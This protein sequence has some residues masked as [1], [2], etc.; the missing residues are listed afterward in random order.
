MPLLHRIKKQLRACENCIKDVIYDRRHDRKAQR[1]GFLFRCLALPF[2]TIVR[3][4]EQAYDKRWLRSQHLGC[5]VIVVGNLTVGGTGKTPIVEKLTR[6]LQARG[7]RVG[8]L[9]RGYKSKKESFLKK[10]MHWLF[11]SVPPPPKVVSD[12]KR[13]LLPYEIAGDEPLLLA[14]NLPE[15]CVVVDK[16]RVKAGQYAVQNLNCDTLIL[17]DGFQYFQLKGTFYILLIDATYP[18]GNGIVLPRGILREPLKHMKRAQFIFLTKSDRV[19]EERLRALERFVR[20]Y[21][22]D[23]PILPCLHVPKYFQAVNDQ[24]QHELSWIKGKRVAALSGIASPKLFEQF[25]SDCGAK[26][27]YKEHFLD[28]HA[29]TQE[30]INEFFQKAKALDAEICVTTEKDAVRIQDKTFLLPFYFLRMEIEWVKGTQPFE[31]IL[32]KLANLKS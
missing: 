29:Y 8:I 2:Y 7:R 9:S 26:I 3:L 11:H 23:A 24:I 25:L 6:A 30:D 32:Q 28:H 31:V 18:F 16:D 17:D 15:A 19:S 5:M 20:R 21:N 13:C 14:K 12:G 27:I 22:K 1:L 4:R 10:W